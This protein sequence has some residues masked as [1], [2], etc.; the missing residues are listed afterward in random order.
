VFGGLPG[1][2]LELPLLRSFTLIASDAL[3]DE[4]DE[5]LRIKF[6]V[7]IADADFL[8]RRLEDVAQV[9]RPRETLNAI[10]DDPD[11]NRVLECAIAGSANL[12]VGG[13][14]HLLKLSS[15]EGIAIVTPRQFM[16]SLDATRPD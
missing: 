1:D 13:D 3:L 16:D 5:K 7:S 9:V 11:D 2:L 14:R 8:R 6:G 12:I 15:F 10:T 4:L